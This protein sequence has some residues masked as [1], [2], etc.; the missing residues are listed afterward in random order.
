M[1]AR[2]D[3]LLVA[4]EAIRDRRSGVPGPRR[5]QVVALLREVLGRALVVRERLL[6]LT[7]IDGL[8]RAGAVEGVL[9]LRRFRWGRLLRRAAATLPEAALRLGRRSQGDD[10]QGAGQ[11]G[12][13]ERARTHHLPSVRIDSGPILSDPPHLAQSPASRASHARN[14]SE[15]HL[16]RSPGRQILG[17]TE[18]VA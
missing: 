17:R 4:A 5:A 15:C 7:A 10:Q 9:A 16:T 18:R 12:R 1:T 14:S 11:E 13:N 2:L 6:T 8:D 3:G